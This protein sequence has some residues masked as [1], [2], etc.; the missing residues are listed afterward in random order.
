M[1]FMLK[2][3]VSMARHW[4]SAVFGIVSLLV[5]EEQPVM[6]QVRGDMLIVEVQVL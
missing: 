5:V 6:S 2:G 3:A 4:E 1:V